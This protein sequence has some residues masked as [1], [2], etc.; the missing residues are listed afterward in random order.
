MKTTHIFIQSST[1]NEDNQPIAIQHI[2]TL[3]KV[4][5]SDAPAHVMY[6]DCNIPGIKF[7]L[8]CNKEIYWKYEK[9]EQRDKDWNRITNAT[10]IEY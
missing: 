7:E 5:L 8:S 6:P 2:L 10:V 3:R 4:N 1:E 9:K